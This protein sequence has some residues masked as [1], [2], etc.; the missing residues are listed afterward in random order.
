[1]SNSHGN[2]KEAGANLTYTRRYSRRPSLGCQICKTRH[3]KVRRDT[4]TSGLSWTLLRPMIDFASVSSISVI[5]VDHIVGLVARRND[6]APG[7]LQRQIPTS[8][9]SQSDDMGWR[10]RNLHLG[11]VSSCTVVKGMLTLLS[12]RTTST[13][14]LHQQFHVPE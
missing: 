12:Y 2:V 14:V 6:N 5:R 7:I 10:K 9:M 4:R 1:M 3:V 11:G 13:P 8:A